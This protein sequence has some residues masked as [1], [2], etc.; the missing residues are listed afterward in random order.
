MITKYKISTIAVC[1]AMFAASSQAF[2]AASV[3]SLGGAG[4]YTSASSAASGTSVSASKSS[5]SSGAY[6]VPSTAA[7]AGSMRVSPS[8]ASGAT[9]S[10]V[11]GN[12]SAT[13]S[14]AASN[15]RL[16]I[17]R[18]LGGASSVG[19]GSSSGNSGGTS[20]STGG[21]FDPELAGEL[22]SEIDG[23]QRDN[24][25]LH[26]R[27]DAIDD[28]T[29]DLVDH[30][31]SVLAESSEVVNDLAG[32]VGAIEQELGDYVTHEELGD[33]VTQEELENAILGNDIDLSG[34]AKTEEVENEIASAIADAIKDI[35]ENHYT[36]G[37]IDTMFGG[38]GLADGDYIL[39]ISNG[40]KQW[41]KIEI[42]Q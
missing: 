24:E 37:E 20:G 15:Q 36:K 3:R 10:S 31:E 42:V 39:T 21:G 23:L 14:R 27:V 30:V 11:S 29:A 40:Q 35:D 32:R 41:T 8:A 9:A 17:G 33:Y 7:R 25:Q 22:R 34:Y 19:G 18:I 26:N 4:T 13:G 5:K 28:A 1:C 2:G 6:A 16:S 38:S 12:A